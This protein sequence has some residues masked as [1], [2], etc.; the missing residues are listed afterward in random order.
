MRTSTIVMIALAVAAPALAAKPHR[1]GHAKTHSAASKGAKGG[2]KGAAKGHSQGHAS[3]ED[4]GELME[5]LRRVDTGSGAIDWS[6]FGEDFLQGLESFGEG[7]VG[8]SNTNSRR[9]YYS[10]VDADHLPHKVARSYMSMDD[11]E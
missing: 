6:T 5:L 2:F 10:K 7:A 8:M 11:L 1:G 3:R 9:H 4:I